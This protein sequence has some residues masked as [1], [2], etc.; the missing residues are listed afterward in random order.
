MLCEILN[1]KMQEEGPFKTVVKFHLDNV[2]LN[3]KTVLVR[4]SNPVSLEEKPQQEE[5]E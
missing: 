3:S 5:K 4:K 2:E 1:N